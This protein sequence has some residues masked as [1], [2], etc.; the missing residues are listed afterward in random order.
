MCLEIASVGNWCLSL[1]R[2][3]KNWHNYMDYSLEITGIRSN[4]LLIATFNEGC[5]DGQDNQES[6]LNSEKCWQRAL[7]SLA[8]LPILY[9]ITLFV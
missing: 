7:L 8:Y 3:V 1:A 6:R 2:V 4:C 5:S 9:V